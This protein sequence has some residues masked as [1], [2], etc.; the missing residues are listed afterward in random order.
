MKGLP[1]L[2]IIEEKKPVERGRPSKQ[3]PTY[4]EPSYYDEDDIQDL[5][6]EDFG[7]TQDQKP[8]KQSLPDYNPPTYNPPQEEEYEDEEYDYEVDEQEDA[9]KNFKNGYKDGQNEEELEKL[10]EMAEKS[11]SSVTGFFSKMKK[12]KTDK[13]KKPKKDTAFSKLSQKTRIYIIIV[14]VILVV[15]I[16]LSLIFRKSVSKSVKYSFV[17]DEETYITYKVTADE[18][19]T[20]NLQKTFY[21]SQN[22]LVLCETDFINL[23]PGEQEVKLDC[24]NYREPINSTKVKD[25]N[26]VVQKNN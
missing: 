18:D 26:I 15:F 14:S 19:M 12:E 1:D 16:A 13:P 10:Q 6:D 23:N 24:V 17:K 25:E 3:L 20:V 9:Y 5:T 7:F 2:D 22:N 21:D 11:K 8:K 4:E